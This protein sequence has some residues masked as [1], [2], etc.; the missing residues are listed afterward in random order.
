MGTSKNKLIYVKIK[1]SRFNLMNKCKVILSSGSIPWAG[2]NQAISYSIETGYDGLE[3]LPTRIIVRELENSIK[4]YGE[5]AWTNCFSNLN[6]IKSIHQNWRLDIG[7]DKEYKINFSWSLF[8]T[9]I[10]ILLFP[11]NYKSKKVIATISEKLYVPVVVHDISK[12]WTHDDK[13]FSG[14]ILLEMIG[15]KRDPKEIKLWL[16]EK[17]HKI[18]V[19][20]RDDQSLLW[21][22]NYGFK[23]WRA[24]WEWIGLQNIE[25]IQLT[26][27]GLNGLKKILTH[28][29]SNAEEQFLWL[30]KQNWQG[31][32][33]VEVNPLILFIVTR[34]RVK[35]GLRTIADFVKQTIGKG[36]NWSS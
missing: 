24:F 33:T 4:V 31:V 7:S 28:S 32:V 5:N 27:I 35:R 29:Q 3:I 12:E 34:G 30:H 26:L 36:D 6:F 1:F 15:I 14:G 9:F 22:S 13:E 10:R 2:I 21:A 16:K 25:G 19:D 20:T 17:Q 8:Y 11:K 18:V 23:N